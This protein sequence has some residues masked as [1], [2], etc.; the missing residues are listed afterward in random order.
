MR[1]FYSDTVMRLVRDGVL[2]T[3][4]TILVTCGGEVDRD[5]FVRG[6]FKK[7]TISNVD[8]RAHPPD[9]APFE[10]KFEDA[11]RL[12]AA[13]ESFDFVV[14][15]SGLHH[16]RSPHRALLE[17]YRVARRGVIVFEPRAGLITRLGQRLGFAQQY[18]L[19]AVAANDMRY[20]GVENT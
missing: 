15:H 10:W 19:A 8:S 7:V 5:T 11:E 16:C 3:E 12:S 1:D 4:S 2:S 6:G 18:E 13:D 20:G 17:M 14:A 9:F